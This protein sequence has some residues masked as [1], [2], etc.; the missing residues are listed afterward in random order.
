MFFFN[1]MTMNYDKAN[2]TTVTVAITTST[3][4]NTTNNNDIDMS[5]CHHHLEKHQ[6]GPKR[7]R[8]HVSRAICKFLFNNLLIFL[9]IIFY[10]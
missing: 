2:G 3:T 8:R 5:P 4:N 7:H 1:T 9:L 6:K 10:R